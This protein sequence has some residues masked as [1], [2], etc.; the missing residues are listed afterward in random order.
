MKKPSIISKPKYAV[1]DGRF[2]WKQPEDLFD[3]CFREFAWSLREAKETAEY[4]GDDSVICK[5]VET[6][7]GTEYR[8]ITKFPKLTDE[9][10]RICQLMFG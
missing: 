1:F 5:V 8:P 3:T 4:T 2:W 7:E 6:K 10:E 9:E